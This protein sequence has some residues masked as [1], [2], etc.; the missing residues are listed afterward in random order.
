MSRLSSENIE[1]VSR[2]SLQVYPTKFTA[3]DLA[4]R[5]EWRSLNERLFTT[6]MRLV[7]I[8]AFQCILLSR[9]I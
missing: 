9:V 8:C 4:G 7:L 3:A 6:A 2:A 1:K 5:D